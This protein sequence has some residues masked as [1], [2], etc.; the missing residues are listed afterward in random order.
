M[1]DRKLDACSGIDGPDRHKWAERPPLE[2]QPERTV[3][4]FR[5]G[6]ELASNWPEESR[7]RTEGLAVRTAG[8]VVRTGAEELRTVG[9]EQD[10]TGVGERD[11]RPAL[12]H[13]LSVVADRPVACRS[14]ACTRVCTP[15]CTLVCTLAHEVCTMAEAG[16]PEAERDCCTLGPKERSTTDWRTVGEQGVRQAGRQ[17]QGLRGTALGEW[18]MG[19]VR[20]DGRQRPLV[21]TPVCCMPAAGTV[22]AGTSEPGVR[23]RTCTHQRGSRSWSQVRWS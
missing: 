23:W 1:R 13:R 10:G 9:H 21:C 2:R 16:M 12:A 17:G 14:L 3:A 15:V 8:P 4:G 18:G 6:T 7:A 11:T 20:A 19:Q 22:L 5:N